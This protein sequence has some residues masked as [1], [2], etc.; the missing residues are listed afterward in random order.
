MRALEDSLAKEQERNWRLEQ[1]LLATQKSRARLQEA[2]KRIADV[3]A[4][5]LR[6]ELAQPQDLPLASPSTEAPGSKAFDGAVD[7]FEASLR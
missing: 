6:Q 2:L 5:D 7:R 3:L 1:E 4:P